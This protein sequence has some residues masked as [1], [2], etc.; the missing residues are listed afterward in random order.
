MTVKLFTIGDSIS[1]GFMSGAAA[2]TE[3]C[4]ST[5][6]SQVLGIQDYQ[7]I[8]FQDDLKFKYDIELIL[9]TLEDAYGSN[10]RG[11][12]WFGV[13]QK[14]NQVFDKSE[15]YFER[16]KGRIGKSMNLPLDG[17]HNVAVEGMDVGDAW[18]VTPESAKHTV[19][20][21][22]KKEKKDGFLDVAS[23]S[24]SR[25]A[26]RVLN[27]NANPEYMQYSAVSWLQHHAQ[28]A[29]VENIILWLGAN[30]AL[31]TVL[32][33]KIK[34]TPG[35]GVKVLQAD[36][37][38][39]LEWNLWHPSDFQ[40][41]Y[42]TLLDKTVEA[43]ADNK[44]DDWH[45][46]IGNVPLVTIAPI[47]KGVGEP[48]MIQDPA[49]SSRTFR[50]FQYYTY[51]PFSKDTGLKTGPYLKFRDA[52]FIDKTILK[53]NAIIKQLVAEK[54][55]E[56]AREAFH[57][58]DISQSL[59]DMAWKRNSG[60]PTYQFPEYFN[61]IYPPVDTKY[62]HTDRRGNIEKG[63]IFSLDG[64]HPSAIG[65]GIIAWEFLKKMQEVG[66]APND[67][68]IHWPDIFANDTLRQKPITL[69]QE[70]YEHD[71]LIQL[72]SDICSFMGQK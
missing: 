67:T 50:Y 24:F 10:I 1:Q 36:R 51:F 18:M 68:D 41:E 29:G 69:M 39:R 20:K 32:D 49:G 25:N 64:V 34:P 33:L 61:W 12:E 4:Y 37:K 23:G 6:L 71:K 66:K 27:P 11:L 57:L 28:Q 13:L 14:V 7:Y 42:S 40:A 17:F 56:L 2:N 21:L 54:N 31:G 59:T 44:F 53:F 22:A 63:G 70:L 47:A 9:R 3:L 19:D 8:K 38:K 58:V 46:F 35:D 15:T 55:D 5:I 52:L 30:N 65:Q 60:N 45:C 72:I 26:F 16:G 62:Y 43:L 48:R